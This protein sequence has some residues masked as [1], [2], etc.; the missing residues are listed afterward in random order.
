MSGTVLH[1]LNDDTHP[2]TRSSALSPSKP[3][4]T[5]SV[6]TFFRQARLP[7]RLLCVRC[8]GAPYAEEAA[9][10]LAAAAFDVDVVVAAFETAMRGTE[11][12]CRLG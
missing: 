7:L 6:S 9:F 3:S 8:A 1:I 5:G 12:K 10:C 4:S 2:V 11:S